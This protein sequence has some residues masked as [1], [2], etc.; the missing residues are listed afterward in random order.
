[1]A[2]PT[3]TFVFAKW[4]WTENSTEKS[5][6][7]NPIKFT[8]TADRTL[9]ANFAPQQTVSYVDEDGKDASQLC[10]LVT[11]S[12]KNLTGG[13]YAVTENVTLSSLHLVDSDVNLI[14]CDGATLSLSDKLYCYRNLKIY[15]QSGSTGCIF[16]SGDECAVTVRKSSEHKEM[17]SSLSLYGGTIS[18]SSTGLDVSYGADFAAVSG[19]TISGGTIGVSNGSGNFTLNSGE[20]I[21]GNTGVSNGGTFT[22][23]GGTI[24]CGTAGNGWYGVYNSGVFTMKDGEVSGTQY[25]MN[26]N[27]AGMVTLYGGTV[28]STQYGVNNNGD[29]TVTVPDSSQTKTVTVIGGI[30]AVS[31]KIQNA[32]EGT[33][34]DNTDG[35]ETGTHLGAAPDGGATDG[36]KKIRFPAEYYLVIANADPA[37]GGTVSGARKYAS[38]E[39]ATLKASAEEDF[40]FA[41]MKWTWTENGTEKSCTDNPYVFVVDGNRTL[42]AVFRRPVVIWMEPVKES[43][44]QDLDVAAYVKGI[45]EQD[46]TAGG[47]IVFTLEEAG[48]TAQPREYQADVTRQSDGSLKAVLPSA[49]IGSVSC[50]IT[51]TFVPGESYPYDS[52]SARLTCNRQRA[53]RTI[54]AQETYTVK[55]GASF[56]LGARTTDPTEYND[57][58]TYQVTSEDGNP[59]LSVDQNGKV[60]A[61]QPGRAWIVITLRDRTG[62][63][64]YDVQKMVTVTVTVTDSSAL[65]LKINSATRSWTYDGEYHT[66]Q[67]YAVRFNNVKVAADANSDG[68]EFTLPTGDTLKITPEDAGA[69]G[70]RDYVASGR[71][72][73]Y[74]YHIPNNQGDYFVTQNVGTLSIT[75]APL[76]ITAKDQTC[77]YNGSTQGEGDTVYEDPDQISGKVDVSG[78]ISGDRLAGI[79]LFSQGKEAGEYPISAKSAVVKRGE[80]TV[81]GNYSISYVAGTLKIT[82][83]KDLTITSATKSWTYDG[84]A[85][86]AQIYTVKYDQESPV[87]GREGQTAFTLSTGDTLTITPKDAGAAGVTNYDATYDGNNAYSYTVTN[88]DKYEVAAN[89]GTLSIGKRSVTVKAADQTAELNGSIKPFTTGSGMAAL[90]GAL[91]GHTLTAVTLTGSG[92]AAATTSGSITPSAAE[93]KNGDQDVSCNYAVTYEDGVLTVTRTVP[94]A[95][96]AAAAS[97]ITYGDTLDKSAITGSMKD[98]NNGAAVPGTF[99]WKE[100]AALPAVSDSGT[101][102]YRWTFTPDDT[103]NYNTAEGELTLSVKPRPVT[104]KAADQTVDLYG[105]ITAFAKDPQTAS[106]TGALQGH[107]LTAVTLTGSGTAA[108]TA[109]GSITPSAAVIKNGAGKDVTGNYAVTYENGVLVVN[110]AALTV[111]ALDQSYKYNETAQGEDNGTY[112]QGLDQKVSVKG[113]RG[114]DA[115]TGITL[116]GTAAEPG[117]YEGKIVPS[118]AVIN[119][120]PEAAKNYEITY[121]GGKL[122]IRQAYKLHVDVQTGGGTASVSPEFAE[123]GEE[124]QVSVF[125]A[126]G[127]DLAKLSCTPQGGGEADLTETKSF[128]MG[129]VPV[130]LTASFAP[131]EYEAVEGGKVSWT[132]GSR[133]G[134]SVKV[135][136][137][138]RDDSTLQHFNDAGKIVKIDGAEL[139]G[140]EFTAQTGCVEITLGRKTLQKLSAGRHTVTILFRD[141]SLESEV[142]TELTILLPEGGGG[143]SPGTGD[144][145]DPAL[146]AAL[147]LLSA[148]WFTALGLGSRKRRKPRYAGKH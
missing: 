23:N 141:G 18:A 109:S 5:S 9:T 112:T 144:G 121:R 29:G 118:A 70:V 43:Q 56:N 119:G 123:A 100:P 27:G 93:I 108:A 115:L 47:K 40:G 30:Q 58:W 131:I 82:D 134:V 135:K 75:P 139:A 36:Y 52:A 61:K 57:V 28:S 10:T 143:Y 99:V 69:S 34:W 33:G 147:M 90:T 94:A 62:E 49:E 105:S 2:D 145:S 124:V 101:T 120:D 80:N 122:T 117:E 65:Y 37:A 81:T 129:S 146:W 116:N 32:V 137:S 15:G 125:P 51:A 110:K 4:T 31:G 39:T 45:D 6:T 111:T 78:L 136:R 132:K 103:E 148:G 128:V 73:A 97:E 66:A 60:T 50:E 54:A 106:L 88:S 85:H 96:E 140:N 59:V 98:K 38:G 46:G 133:D 91:R 22:M 13:W 86:T 76:T 104:V 84:E 87:T 102:K 25:G 142:T 12:T 71:E 16:C 79:Q 3:A 14:L 35:T 7:D 44:D 130:A 95:D 89:A 26:N 68:R 17:S 107:A 72:N 41:F 83:R 20:I 19:G 92:T 11:A 48:G 21:G 138:P 1:M 24:T 55:E 64:Y 77:I 126:E 113:L 42:T 8:V 63:L 114:D 74:N 53:T 127:Y 67:E